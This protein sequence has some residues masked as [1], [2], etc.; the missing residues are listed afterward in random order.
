MYNCNI[1]IFV[2]EDSDNEKLLT[3][4]EEVNNLHDEL[5]PYDEWDYPLLCFANTYELTRYFCNYRD[6]EYGLEKISRKHGVGFSL[7]F[8]VIDDEEVDFG[9][10]VHDPHGDLVD[11]MHFT[12]VTNESLYWLRENWFWHPL[13]RKYHLDTNMVWRDQLGHFLPARIEEEQNESINW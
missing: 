10:I 1:R 12:H 3:A 2:Y 9:R 13:M 5:V 11:F 8:R 4:S 7:R 6:L